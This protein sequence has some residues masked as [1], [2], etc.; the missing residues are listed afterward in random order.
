MKRQ[1]QE[2]LRW[3]RRREPL[4]S[5]NESV[6]AALRKDRH[7]SRFEGQEKG[8]RDGNVKKTGRVS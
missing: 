8:Q 6:R 2:E 5:W 3:N 7:L 4:D 1:V